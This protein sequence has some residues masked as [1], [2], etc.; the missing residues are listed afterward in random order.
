MALH[1][2]IQSFSHTNVVRNSDTVLTITVPKYESYATVAMGSETITAIDIPAVALQSTTDL[3]ALSGA[4]TIEIR[5]RTV[6]YSGT[7][8]AVREID[9]GK[10]RGAEVATSLSPSP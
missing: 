9:D 2:H 7:L 1:K 3:T 10:I 8:F 6:I 4:F 5:T